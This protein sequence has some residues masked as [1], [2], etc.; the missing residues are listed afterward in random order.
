MAV[1]VLLLGFVAMLVVS[2]LV[3]RL[4]GATPYTVL[5]GSMRPTMPPGTLVV[6]KPVDPEA[7]EVG[8]VVTVQ[9]RSG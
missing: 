1:W 6:A 7:L 2:V 5:T 9:L 3:P 4:A 8:D